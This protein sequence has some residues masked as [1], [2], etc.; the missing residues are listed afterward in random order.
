MSESIDVPIYSTTNAATGTT[1]SLQNELRDEWASRKHINSTGYWSLFEKSSDSKVSGVIIGA[2]Y[3]QLASDAP[4]VEESHVQVHAPT[5]V[6]TAYVELEGIEGGDDGSED[7]DHQPE[8][9]DDGE[10][11]DVEDEAAT[12]KA[13]SSPYIEGSEVSGVVSSFPTSARS[14]LIYPKS[15]P[16]NYI[17]QRQST[18][19]SR[20]LGLEV[21]EATTNAAASAAP[22]VS[23]VHPGQKI[24]T[25]H[26]HGQQ[27]GKRE[28]IR[29]KNTTKMAT[30]QTEALVN[31]LKVIDADESLDAGYTVPSNLSAKETIQM[32][33]AR[34]IAHIHKMAEDA[35]EVTEESK[36]DLF[37]GVRKIINSLPQIQVSSQVDN[38][39]SVFGN[40]DQ[41]YIDLVQ[42][43]QRFETTVFPDNTVPIL[44]AG[45]AYPRLFQFTSYDSF[46]P[47]N[48]ISPFESQVEMLKHFAHQLRSP[49]IDDS[50]GL[51][52]VLNTVPGNGKTT[53]VLGLAK[54]IQRSPH[55]RIM[56]KPG[57]RYGFNARNAKTKVGGRTLKLLYVTHKNLLPVAQQVGS[58]LHQDTPFGIAYT[59]HSKSKGTK[60]YEVGDNNGTCYTKNGRKHSYI[61]PVVLLC[62]PDTAI[63]ILKKNL[64]EKRNKANGRTHNAFEAQTHYTMFYDE[65]TA[66]GMDQPIEGNPYVEELSKLVRYMPKQTILSCATLKNIEAYPELI[67]A[68]R[69][70]YP[71]AICNTVNHS[72]IPIGACIRGFD[73]N[74]CLPHKS[75]T[76]RVQLASVIEKLNSEQILQ[77]F[78]TPKIV[79][80]MFTRLSSMRTVPVKFQ[81]STYFVDKEYSQD[82]FQKL[83][84]K[85]L[86]LVRDTPA[87]VEVSQEQFITNFCG[88]SFTSAAFNTENI[89]SN[90]PRMSSQTLVVASN[91]IARFKTA[92]RSHYNHILTRFG[93]TSFVG[94]SARYESALAEWTAAESA[95]LKRQSGLK[96]ATKDGKK[97]KFD[98]DTLG[99][100]E[101]RMHEWRKLHPVPSMSL[102]LN[103]RIQHVAQA[104]QD[105]LRLSIDYS[106]EDYALIQPN[107]GDVEADDMLKTMLAA[108]VGVYSSALDASYLNKL[109]ELMNEGQMCF[110]FVNDEICYGVNYPIENI[111]ILDTDVMLRR[112]VN[113][114]LQLIS[115]AGRKGKSDRANIWMSD[116]VITRLMNYITNPEF[117][118]IETINIRTACALS[119]G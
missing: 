45:E 41:S 52:T 81:F 59:R 96:G 43:F 29:A 13:S 102:P 118:D 54:Q 37:F 36:I 87:S 77:K 55:S 89:L 32:S 61:P 71:R 26:K 79:H 4:Y 23:K 38:T 1:A 74:V 60:I 88:P 106:T 99:S 63:E 24:S 84:I 30:I 86:E 72:K 82:N 25:K 31:S 33:L 58:L 83:A 34:L 111:V 76:T 12:T 9:E 15:N 113:T 7:G 42:V 103:L 56:Y 16:A 40:S 46:I 51:L 68:F 3:S 65:P 64:V 101:T 105:R 5:H 14:Q 107:S 20:I 44:R 114:L 75:C 57:N 70:K 19:F 93:A 18:K 10:F 90:A 94:I 91:P 116:P 97:A 47:G 108:G 78:Y 109:V 27:S 35:E 92:V 67:A 11:E 53:L 119:M 115:R 80:D 100:V 50:T 112:S 73:G 49:S 66:T 6:P 98:K 28:A 21:V 17:T 62:S 22:T 39:I 8:G 2:A 69:S 117:D 104:S 110:V 48:G 95:E 85:Y